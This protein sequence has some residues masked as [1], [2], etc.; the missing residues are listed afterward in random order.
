[1]GGVGVI[2]TS[3]LV[4]RLLGSLDLSGPMTSISWTHNYYKQFYYKI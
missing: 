1:M 2:S 3:V 4:R